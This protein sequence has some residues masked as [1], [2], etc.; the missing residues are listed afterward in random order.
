MKRLCTLLLAV[1]LFAGCG[2]DND[3]QLSTDPFGE[4]KMDAPRRHDG[5]GF[6]IR[7]LPYFGHDLYC[8]TTGQVGTHYYAFSC[9]F[10]RY[11]NENDP[12]P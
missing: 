8:I 5:Q 2:G 10:V 12:Q 1:A 6:G 3:D 9:D 11:H 4:S 7:I